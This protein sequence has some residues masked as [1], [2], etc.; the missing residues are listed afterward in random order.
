MEISL[1]KWWIC[2]GAAAAAGGDAR[3]AGAVAFMRSTTCIFV[4]ETGVSSSSA[5]ALLFCLS[6]VSS[7]GSRGSGRLRFRSGVERSMS[8][9][10]PSMLGLADP[11]L[12]DRRG[13]VRL[14]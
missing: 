3:L 12:E 1:A 8:K 13:R 10:V 5:C 14:I 2:I 6:H 11:R 9:C 4:A 7:A